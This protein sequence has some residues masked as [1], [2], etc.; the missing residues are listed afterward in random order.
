MCSLYRKTIVAVVKVNVHVGVQKCV[1]IG[2]ALLHK[3]VISITK[4]AWTRSEF[5]VAVLRRRGAFVC[6]YVNELLT[7]LGARKGKYIGE[8]KADGCTGSERVALV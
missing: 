4:N 3:R 2:K 1:G 5:N 8:N 6:A 7:L